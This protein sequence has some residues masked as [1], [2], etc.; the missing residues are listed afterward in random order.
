M[1]QKII[2]SG[3]SGA[4]HG[5]ALEQSLIKGQ[6]AVVGIAAAFVSAEGVRQLI[7][8]L[9]RCGEPECRLIAGIDN[10]ITHPEALRAA[11]IKG[12]NVRLGRSKSGIFHPKLVVAGDRFTPAGTIHELCCFYVGS[13]NLTVGGLVTNVEC[14]L[15]AS[16]RGC[17]VSASEAFAEMWSLAVP[18]TEAELRNY[19][20]RFAE[21]TRRRAASELAD[22]GIADS[23]HAPDRLE[24]LRLQR[25][26]SLPALGAEFAV[27]V[28]AGLQSF[29]G[30]Y[31][32]Q[33]EF[34]RDAAQVI[35]RLI[36]G[37]EADGI[38]HVYCPD[39]ETTRPMR[40]GFY[41]DNGMFRLNVPNEV[42]GVAWAR[43]HRDGLAVVEQGPPGGAPLRLWLLRPGAATSEIIG[44]SAALGTWGKT[45]T[46]AYGWY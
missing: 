42:P 3:I 11:Q 29:T 44:R 10:A 17:L 31:R 39:D 35:K 7:E 24:D 38:I 36:Q 28:W 18:A 8:I 12:W 34:P 1:G 40:Y 27:G 13:S 21:R 32:F 20:V 6:P 30:G 43:E 26:P 46:R 5:L 15:V 19:S 22:L 14:G 25:P 23:Q 2:L 9:R 4:H 16:G 33:V 37:R 41:K 45:R